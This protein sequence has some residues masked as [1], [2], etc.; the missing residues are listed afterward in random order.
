MEIIRQRDIYDVCIVGSGAGG[1]MAA[2][3]LTQAGARVALL[4][5]GSLWDAAKDARMFAWPYDS[6][7][8]GAPTTDRPYGEF[9]AAIGGWQIEGEPYT[10][11]PGSRS[12]SACWET[13][14]CQ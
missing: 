12:S 9:D 14:N 13:S 4:E 3:V 11:A 8:R 6:P 1:G 7:R 2:M 10:V 5:A